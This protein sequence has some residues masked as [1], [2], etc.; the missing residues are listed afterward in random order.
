MVLV[1]HVIVEGMAKINLVKGI[2]R[3]VMRAH[4]RWRRT[5]RLLGVIL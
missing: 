1:F 5:G 4:K 2:A 3:E